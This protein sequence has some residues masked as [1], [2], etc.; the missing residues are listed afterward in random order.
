MDKI[1]IAKE[2]IKL[3]Q[4]LITNK[5]TGSG[6]FK[7]YKETYWQFEGERNNFIETTVLNGIFDENYFN[8][9]V[10]ET[11]QYLMNIFNKIKEKNNEL[12]FK[13]FLYMVGGDGLTISLQFNTTDYDEDSLKIVTKTLSQM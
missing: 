5:T 8:K 4:S 3:A 10:E 9:R 12:E 6:K 7:N 13:E 11:K 1:K 2:L